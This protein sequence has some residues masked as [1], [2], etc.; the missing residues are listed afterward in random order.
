MTAADVSPQ[1]RDLP[2]ADVQLDQTGYIVTAEALR[3][4]NGKNTPPVRILHMM[5]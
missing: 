1:T 2:E 4:A 5:F 3:A